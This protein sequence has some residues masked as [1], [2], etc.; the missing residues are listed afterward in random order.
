MT[1]R[2]AG[3]LV[4][5]HETV[6][7]SNGCMVFGTFA[8]APTD[9]DFATAGAIGGNPVIA[10]ARAA[11]RIAPEGGAASIS[12][13]NVATLHNPRHPYRRSPVDPRGD[14]SEWL[15]LGPQLL[16]AAS[17]RL[18]GRARPFSRSLVPLD[19]RAHALVRLATRHL[20]DGRPFDSLL[21]EETL[22]EAVFRVLR[23]PTLGAEPKQ[24]TREPASHRV[25][26]ERL[27]ELIACSFERR[28]TLEALATATGASPFLI[29]RAF[30]RS[31]GVT[32]HAYLSGLRLRAAL[33][34]LGVGQPDLLSLALEVGFCSHSH[35]TASF[36]RA[37][38]A[39]PR[40][41]RSRASAQA[42]RRL[43]LRLPA[44]AR[45]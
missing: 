31:T 20:A 7:W 42:V 10:F 15:S 34:Q 27:R 4:G 25:L 40:E 24:G 14:H 39:T 28:W 3:P 26:V 12:D 44:S 45:I 9:A 21:V 22:I 29:C 11:V 37:F 1:A 23:S 33:L 41:F 36:S 13:P 18:A 2:L 35:F 16:F 30:R 32:L 19:A 6:L 5:P 43:R 8:A 17:P 38:G